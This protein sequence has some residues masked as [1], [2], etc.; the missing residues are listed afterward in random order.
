[1]S[2]IL[3]IEDEYPMR[4]A[5]EDLLSAE[6][7]RV[8]T[9]ADGVSGLNGARSEQ[10]DLIVLDVMLPGID[11][12]ALVKELRRVGQRIPVLLLTAKGGVRDRVTG[13]DAGADDYLAK[14][15]STEELL[16][17][18]RALLRRAGRSEVPVD[19]LRLGELEVD[20]RRR[21]ARRG[22]KAAH[23]TTKEFEM[24]RLLAEARGGVVSRE[25]FLDLIWGYG[26][27]PTTR[28]VDTH[29]AA[30]RAKI[31]P[32]PARPRHLL[33]VH[34]AGYRLVESGPVTG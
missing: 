23:F 9:A 21:T 15:F 6:G 14:P 18:V 34:G 13:L 10:P 8:L 17:R 19:H 25:Q 20:F 12:F 1:M 16:A 4:R 22:R 3:V 33:T 2:R 24:L 5:L 26:S 27:F 30:I 7:H 28:T 32:N 11:G 29:V 31:E